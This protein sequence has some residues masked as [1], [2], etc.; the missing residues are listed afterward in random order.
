MT[1]NKTVL[2]VFVEQSGMAKAMKAVRF[3][4]VWG[5]LYEGLGRA[6]KMNEVGAMMG[7]DHTTVWRG[8][9][10]FRAVNRNH[11]AER[12]WKSLPKAVRAGDG[13]T[14]DER[15]AD[16]ASAPWVLS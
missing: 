6:P 9:S 1:V 11:P 14:D 15:I 3:L 5:A 4:A 13:R 12:I 16:V 10:A 8:S 7:R 2:Q